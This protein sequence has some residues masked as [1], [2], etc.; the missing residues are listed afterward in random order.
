[1][2]DID[3]YKN[4]FD[5]LRDTSGNLILDVHIGG[6]T[7][8]PSASLDLTKAK[9]KVQDKLFDELRKKA[10]QLKR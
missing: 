1:M 3:K 9:S 5:L 8:H 6:T 4:V 7:K 2:K 10:G